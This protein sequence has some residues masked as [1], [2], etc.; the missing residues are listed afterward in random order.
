[1]ARSAQP[2]ALPQQELGVLAASAIAVN[3]VCALVGSGG[4]AAPVATFTTTPIGVALN[5]AA[6]GVGLNLQTGGDALVT[7]A[8]SL[9]EGA[10]VG[11]ASAAGS[12]GGLV[13]LT[14][15]GTSV[16]ARYAIGRALDAAAAGST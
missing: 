5:D 4:L 7:A 9:G 3:Q 14:N 8:A 12:A 2:P 13:P 6:V 1:M 10:L 11:L 16:P 15:T